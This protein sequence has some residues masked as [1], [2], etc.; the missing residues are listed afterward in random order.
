L[1]NELSRMV[2]FPKVGFGK[3]DMANDQGILNLYFICIKNNYESMP[4]NNE[5]YWL[6][7]F[8]E[9][10]NYKCEQYVMLKYPKTES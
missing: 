9:R 1:C 2:E 3:T 5:Y 6:F 8:W 4:L 10:S 7:D